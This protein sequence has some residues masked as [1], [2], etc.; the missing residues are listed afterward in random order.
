MAS[1]TM[2]YES[3]LDVE[4]VVTSEVDYYHDHGNPY[5]TPDNAYPEEFEVN[6]SHITEIHIN[7]KQVTDPHV[8]EYLKNLLGEAVHEDINENFYL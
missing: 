6:D 1:G 8:L 4:V 2:A 3:I 5:G 7:N